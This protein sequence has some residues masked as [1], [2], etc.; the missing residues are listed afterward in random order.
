MNICIIVPLLW[1]L[2]FT[3]CL[4]VCNLLPK[5]SAYALSNFLLYITLRNLIL[6]YIKN[7][8]F[9]SLICV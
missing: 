1:Q 8:Y 4:Y 9:Y 5:M 7:I 3:L 2:C 6:M